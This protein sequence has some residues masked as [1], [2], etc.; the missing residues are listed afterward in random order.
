MNADSATRGSA[1][2]RARTRERGFE[3]RLS[4][5]DPD[6]RRGDSSSRRGASRMESGA[7]IVV[8]CRP[9]RPTARRRA[10]LRLRERRKARWTTARWRPQGTASLPPR[11]CRGG[12][13]LPSQQGV[14]W[15]RNPH[16]EAEATASEQRS[17]GHN[18]TSAAHSRAERLVVSSVTNRRQR[19]SAL[20]R[21][22][23]RLAQRCRDASGAKREGR[24]NLDHNREGGGT[25]ALSSRRGGSP[26][27]A[28]C[29]N[30]LLHP[31]KPPV[32]CSG[33]LA[34]G[35]LLGCVLLGV[36]IGGGLSGART[37]A[38][39]GARCYR[40]SAGVRGGA[41]A[42]GTSGESPASVTIDVQCEA[43]GPVSADDA[44]A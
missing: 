1:S 5:R 9:G 42:A 19:R 43:I 39:C 10:R 17:F 4:E 11:G 22:R 18:R 8:D 35:R 23:G 21:V 12:A 15:A 16:S 20:A 32:A 34:R 33:K 26:V 13:P 29:P 3:R 38:R 24:T 30:T 27:T 36:A 37:P 28:P 14:G 40:V 25:P 41:R 44:E 2:L 7:A 6:Q 31:R